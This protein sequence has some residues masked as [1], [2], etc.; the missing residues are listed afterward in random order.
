LARQSLAGC[1]AAQAEAAKLGE[2]VD[3]MIDQGLERNQAPALIASLFLAFIR[4]ETGQNDPFLIKKQDD[5]TRARQAAGAL[6]GLPD[7]LAARVG[8]A[9]MGNALDHFSS[10]EPGAWSESQALPSLGIDHLGRAEARLDPGARVVI[11]ADNAGEE[12]FDR[13]LVSHLKGRGCQVTYV[14]KSGPAQNDLTLADLSAQGQCHGLGRILGSGTDQVGLDPKQVPRPL[15]R[16]LGKADLVIAKGMGHYE[17]LRRAAF[18]TQGKP[19]PWPL[20]FLFL[21]KC[22]PVARSLSLDLGQGV[23]LLAE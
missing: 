17:T 13:L 6:A 15:A 19:S 8:A 4:K 20:L 10:P 16:V 14:V 23:A 2:L 11:L 18:H 22:R 21:V 1:Q 9:I 7:T 3:R 12:C 5:F